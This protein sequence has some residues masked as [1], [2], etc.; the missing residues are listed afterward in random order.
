VS[1]EPERRSRAAARKGSS[2]SRSSKGLTRA[3]GRDELR[4]LRVPEVKSRAGRG[5]I[6]TKVNSLLRFSMHHGGEVDGRLIFM[7]LGATHNSQS[8]TG[9]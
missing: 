7:A 8:S 9:S 6:F 3:T 1:P 2:D 5:A 4:L